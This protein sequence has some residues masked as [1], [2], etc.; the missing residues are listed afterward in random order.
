MAARLGLGEP[1][2]L[3]PP[4]NSKAGN[5]SALSDE[6]DNEWLNVFRDEAEKYVVVAALVVVCSGMTAWL[7]FLALALLRAVE[8]AL[9]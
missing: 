8:W 3:L 2:H 6:P 5:H 4:A 1:V 9:G 7:G